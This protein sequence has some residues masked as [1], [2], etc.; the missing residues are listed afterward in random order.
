MT[1]GELLKKEGG[2]DEHANMTDEERR[3]RNEKYAG[4]NDARG[5]GSG[6]AVQGPPPD[7]N[8]GIFDK[9]THAAKS[10]QADEMDETVETTEITLYA[11][12]FIIDDGPL[13]GLDDPANTKFLEE[14]LS[15]RV[16]R[17]LAESRKDG[18]GGPMNV[19]LADKRAETFTPPPPPAYVAFSGGHSLGSAKADK[20]EGGDADG[21]EREGVFTA[22]QL[23]E[24]VAPELIEDE[25]FTTMQVKTASGKKLRVKANLNIT[26]LQLAALIREQQGAECPE[27]FTLSAG[28]PPKDLTDPKAKIGDAG[29]KGASLSQ[30]GV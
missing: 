16:P 5:G 3:R 12:G 1:F 15:G 6:M 22:A 23:E 18:Q 19:K 29:L 30:K 4:G 25:P 28:F 11:N 21:A 20:A 8:A 2:G 17:E 24:E 27:S 13:R 9:L 14:L 7:E 10:S 26:V